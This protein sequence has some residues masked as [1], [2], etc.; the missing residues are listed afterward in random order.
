[1]ILLG[2]LALTQIT[3]TL[4]LLILGLGLLAFVPFTQNTLE[5]TGFPKFERE[6]AHTVPLVVLVA[7]LAEGQSLVRVIFIE[8]RLLLDRSS[9]YYHL[10]K[11]S[12]LLL[13]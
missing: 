3:A 5:L 1:M 9:A 4:L 2:P 8:G 6:L 7:T 12:A 13:G 10:L 11:S